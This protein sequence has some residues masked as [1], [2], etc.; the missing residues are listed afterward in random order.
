MPHEPPPPRLFTVAEGSRN[1]IGSHSNLEL[2][3]SHSPSSSSSN[4]QPLKKA[5]KPRETGALT[6]AL[7]C[8]VKYF[9]QSPRSKSVAASHGA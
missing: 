4:R 5:Y 7:R 6:Q 3:G 2:T 8:S 9:L 1:T